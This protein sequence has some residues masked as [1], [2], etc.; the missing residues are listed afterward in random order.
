M[1]V[2][3]C[4]WY[5]WSKNKSVENRNSLPQS[6]EA[7]WNWV[8]FLF[9]FSSVFEALI[10][11]SFASA[12]VPI[13]LIPIKNLYACVCVH[14]RDARA[15]VGTSQ[16]NHDSI[17]LLRQIHTSQSWSSRIVKMLFIIWVVGNCILFFIF[18]C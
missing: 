8:S 1:C 4:D 6:R 15:S 3:V 11:P 10:K 5:K 2:S 13:V 16:S 17:L 18:F 9:I 7:L 14:E 12:S